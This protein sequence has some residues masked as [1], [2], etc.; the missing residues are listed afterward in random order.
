[1]NVPNSFFKVNIS[2]ENITSSFRSSK[3]IQITTISPKIGIMVLKIIAIQSLRTGNT[4]EIISELN[5]MKFI[6]KNHLQINQGIQKIYKTNENQLNEGQANRVD[7]SP[8]LIMESPVNICI[9]C[10]CCLYVRSVLIRM[11]M[12]EVIFNFT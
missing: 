2:T 12:D 1:M 4:Q 9:I 10:N 11:N 7:K 6:I 3:K 5:K 8:K